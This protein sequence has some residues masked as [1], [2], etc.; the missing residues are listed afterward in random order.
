MRFEDAL[1]LSPGDKVV[2]RETGHSYIIAGIQVN[3]LCRH[4][5]IRCTHGEIL[6]HAKI[7]FG[8]KF[9]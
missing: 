9:S 3:P 4:I 1:L 8:R 5:F 2:H 6:D 7:K